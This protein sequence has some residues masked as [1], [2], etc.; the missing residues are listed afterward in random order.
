MYLA[1]QLALVRQVK[2]RKQT[3]V[4]GRELRPKNRLLGISSHG[5]PA[6]RFISPWGRRS[7]PAPADAAAQCP[8]T[9]PACS[10]NPQPGPQPAPQQLQVRGSSHTGAIY[11]CL[12]INYNKVI[13]MY[14]LSFKCLALM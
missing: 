13:F 6:D 4:D 2:T 1:L 10:G 7:L 8:E 12:F 5:A 9:P 14:N 11:P 3:N